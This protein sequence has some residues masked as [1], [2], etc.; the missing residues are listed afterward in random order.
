MPSSCTCNSGKSTPLGF[1]WTAPASQHAVATAVAPQLQLL[2]CQS[3]MHICHP[4]RPPA[5]QCT[6]LCTALPRRWVATATPGLSLPQANA[7]TP[8]CWCTPISPSSP[9]PSSALMSHCCASTSSALPPM[10][11]PTPPSTSQGTAVTCTSDRS[12]R[13]RPPHSW[14][15][16]RCGPG[17]SPS[18]GR[19]P[20]LQPD[21]HS[22]PSDTRRMLQ[23]PFG[24]LWSALEVEFGVGCFDGLLPIW[25]RLT[26]IGPGSIR[27]VR[28]WVDQACASCK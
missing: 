4:K 9:T 26:A 3:A 7:S 27:D 23:R 13:P 25:N 10:A 5:H 19:S 21:I 1:H 16:M 14:L 22:L 12:R 20:R 8:A 24:D 28:H 2:R 17:Y 6:A 11:L 18:G 15:H